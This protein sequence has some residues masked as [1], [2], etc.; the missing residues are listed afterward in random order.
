MKRTDLIR[1]IDSLGIAPNKKLGQ[2]FL[3]D[4]QFLDWIVR[5]SE[6][7]KDENILE[8]GPGLGAL[9]ARILDSGAKL[10]AVEFDRKL[11]AYLRTTLVPRGLLLIEGDACKVDLAGIFGRNTEFRV[12]SNLPYSAGTVI[13]AHLLDLELPPR[14]MIVMLQ[15]EV[16]FRF[17][18]PVGSDDYSALSARIAAVYDAKIV[19]TIPPDLFYPRPEVE[20]CIIRLTRKSEL[21][22]FEVRKT[23]SRLARTGFAHR[24]K[25][26]FRQT[27]AVFGEAPLRAAMTIAG[28][29]PDV[30][31][32]RVSPEQMIAMAKFLSAG[33]Q[34]L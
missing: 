20:S 16:A 10:A 30:R 3:A 23:L 4:E 14:E 27:A 7:C 24:R 11:A 13:A 31:A 26:M 33:A 34:E 5:F 15:K 25:K 2:N 12:I 32:E 19:K 1:L 29:D 28:V 21:L 8:I 18:A 17:A 9:T 6:V 22:P